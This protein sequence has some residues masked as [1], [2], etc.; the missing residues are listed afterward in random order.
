MP[1]TL[2]ETREV[3]VRCQYMGCKGNLLYLF[4]EFNW[5][6]GKETLNQSN[7]LKNKIQ[8]QDRQGCYLKK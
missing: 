4:G 1:E 2:F 8:V 7:Q 6:S 5:G 3:I